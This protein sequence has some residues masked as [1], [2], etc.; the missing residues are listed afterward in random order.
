M[1]EAETF[2]ISL[3]SVPG[4]AGPSLLSLDELIKVAGAPDGQ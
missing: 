1:D 3:V 2:G 4:L